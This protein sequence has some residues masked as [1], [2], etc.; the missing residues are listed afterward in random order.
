MK[1]ADL[2]QKALGLAAPW[3]VV[4]VTFDYPYNVS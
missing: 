4:A 3:K 1:E 2:I